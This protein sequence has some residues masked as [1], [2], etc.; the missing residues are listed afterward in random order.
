MADVTQIESGRWGFSRIVSDGGG[1]WTTHA[2]QER[3]ASAIAAKYPPLVNGAYPVPYAMV[4][5]AGHLVTPATNDTVLLP[6]NLDLD[7]LTLGDLTA[8]QRLNLRN[9]LETW[10]DYQF[11]DW[12]GSL[13]SMPGMGTVVATYTAGTLVREVLRDLY[14]Y[15]GHSASRIRSNQA[16]WHNTEYLD[17]FNTD[18]S[19]RWTTQPGCTPGSW[20]S[21]AGEYTFDGD[22]DV[23]RRYS[24]NNAGSIEHEAQITSTVSSVGSRAVGAGVRLRSGTHDGYG[25]SV[26]TAGSTQIWKFVGGVRT[27]LYDA[28]AG[29][30]AAGDWVTLRLA[31]SGGDG[32]N[33]ALA[34]WVNDHNGTKPSD[35]G[36]YGVDA[37]P[38]H[39]YTDTAVDRLDDSTL[40]T[41]QG[42]VCRGNVSGNSTS[43]FFKL[44]AI[45]DRGGA[46]GGAFPFAARHPMAHLLVR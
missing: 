17:D 39:T 44:R 32:A 43:D 3:L 16:E 19:A 42:V 15:L 14:R 11:T 41:D 36:W 20:N 9:F 38:D 30:F 26:A 28:G 21:G 8:A 1:G 46:A 12:D 22:N 10:I 45:A 29:S 25:M 24:A 27:G 23:G 6:R 37:S 33:V 31:A 40:H 7:E 18:P 13:R 2:M 5:L 35:P 4:R 34:A